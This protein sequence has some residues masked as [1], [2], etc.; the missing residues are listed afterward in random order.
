MP[1]IT[2]KITV[3]CF[4]TTCFGSFIWGMAK[5]FRISPNTP[6]GVQ[7]VKALGGLTF[8]LHAMAIS[9]HRH[10]SVLPAVTSIALYLFATLLFWWAVKS[11]GQRPPA[12]CFDGDNPQHLVITG[13][14]RWVRHPFYTAYMLGWL[15]GVAAT[16]QPW[17]LISS[18][19]MSVL[20]IRAAISEERG[21]ATGIM[22]AEFQNYRR[23]TGMFF[24]KAF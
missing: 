21:F 20:Y 2:L 18:M 13:S 6:I 19:L 14:Y 4:F 11:H 12:A 23:T 16:G 7:L 15:A 9:L 1:E 10:T 3:L 5:F 8:L 24:P 22:A 17:L